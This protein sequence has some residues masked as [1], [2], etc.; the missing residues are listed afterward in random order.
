MSRVCTQLKGIC[1]KIRLK[2]RVQSN[3]SNSRCIRSEEKWL[4]GMLSLDINKEFYL[5]NHIKV[6]V[7]RKLVEPNIRFR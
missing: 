3:L 4:M 5:W 2:I 7:T 6:S 1:D